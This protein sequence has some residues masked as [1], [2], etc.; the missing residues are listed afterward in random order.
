MRLSGYFALS[1]AIA[2][3]AATPAYAEGRT[4][5]FD[6]HIRILPHCAASIGFLGSEGSEAAMNQAQISI[7]CSKNIAWSMRLSEDN[8]IGAAT[9]GLKMTSASSDTVDYRT[10]MDS[11]HSTKPGDQTFSGI[12]PAMIIPVIDGQYSDIIAVAVAY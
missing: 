7:N 5:S 11:R 6:V 12:G 1:S 4:G 8:G 2:A 10:I 3:A 9:P